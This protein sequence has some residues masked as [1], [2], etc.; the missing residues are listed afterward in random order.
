ME[1]PREPRG[2]QELRLRI[3]A[4]DRENVL[5]HMGDGEDAN[6]QVHHKIGLATH[7]ALVGVVR[8]RTAD[9]PEPPDTQITKGGA[10]EECRDAASF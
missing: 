9:R 8:V 4:T 5:S 2:T 1:L 7:Y 6:V 10:I 3:Q